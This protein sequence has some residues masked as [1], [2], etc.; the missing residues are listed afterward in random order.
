MR[1]CTTFREFGG[2]WLELETIT[3]VPIDTRMV[4]N[5]LLSA[6]EQDWLRAYNARVRADVL[7]LLRGDRRAAAWLRRQ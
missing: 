3:R 2:P 1:R 7:P 6:D 4:D 5:A